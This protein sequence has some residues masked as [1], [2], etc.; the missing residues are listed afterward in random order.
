MGDVRLL[1][2][3]TGAVTVVPADKAEVEFRSGRAQLPVGA[4][5]KLVGTQSG[6]V[7]EF[8]PETVS[9]AIRDGVFRF[10]TEKDEYAAEAKN[11][12]VQAFAEGVANDIFLPGM[13]DLAA[14]AAGADMKAVAARRE[15]DEGQWGSRLGTVGSFV[16]PGLGEVRAL[17][18]ASRLAA[19]AMPNV[20]AEGA[21]RSLTEMAEKTLTGVIA[22][23]TARAAI[24]N[25]LGHGAVG[26]GVGALATLDEAALGNVE[27]ST[28]TILS[29]MGAGGLIGGVLGSGLGALGKRLSKVDG[30][31]VPGGAETAR[32]LEGGTAQ[33][34]LT[35]NEL[36]AVLEANGQEVDR[37]GLTK[38]WPNFM[39]KIANKATGVAE[40][41][42]QRVMSPAGRRAVL[43]GE[44]ARDAVTRHVSDLIDGLEANSDRFD[45]TDARLAPTVINRIPAGSGDAVIADVAGSFGA[46]RRTLA[47]LVRDAANYGMTPE[48]MASKLK[49]LRARIAEAEGKV[50]KELAAPENILTKEPKSYINTNKVD[51]DELEAGHLPSVKGVTAKPEN[52]EGFAEGRYT[53]EAPEQGV[54]VDYNAN[55][56]KLFENGMRQIRRVGGEG[57]GLKGKSTAGNRLLNEVRMPAEF[58]PLGLPKINDA[59]INSAEDLANKVFEHWRVRPQ[60]DTYASLVND[61][62][63]A[64]QR[65][66]GGFE[67][68]AESL[69][70]G[71][72]VPRGKTRIYDRELKRWFSDDEFLERNGRASRGLLADI[73]ERNIPVNDKAARLAYHELD[74][75]QRLVAAQ[76]R[77]IK[78]LVS[79]AGGLTD[80]SESLLGNLQ[81]EEIWGP[82]A[83]AHR[84]LTDAA[85]KELAARQAV[86]AHFPSKAGKVDRASVHSFTKNMDRVTGEPRV[87]ALADWVDAQNQLAQTVDR[88]TTRVGGGPSHFTAAPLDSGFR[89]NAK[90]L[91]NEYGQVYTRLREDAMALNA[92]DRLLKANR[93]QGVIPG[94]AL[95]S[96]L[97]AAGLGPAGFLGGNAVG[98][99]ILNPGRSARQLAAML[100]FKQQVA[101]HVGSRVERIFTGKGAIRQLPIQA[102]R[103]VTAMIDGSPKERQE[104]Y[105][106]HAKEMAAVSEPQAYVNH[107]TAGLGSVAEAMPQ[108]ASQLALQGQKTLA[109]L[110]NE[111]PKPVSTRGPQAEYDFLGPAKPGKGD[112]NFLNGPKRATAKPS[113]ENIRRYGQV[114]AVATGGTP[115]ILSAI[116]RGN[117]TAAQVR[118]YKSLFPNQDAD[119]TRQFTERLGRGHKMSPKV[120]RAL[121]L[122]LTTERGDAAVIG[123]KQ[124]LYA[125]NIAEEAGGAD[126]LP[127]PNPR[128][129][130]VIGPLSTPTDRLAGFPSRL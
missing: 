52:V 5:V 101:E 90:K 91:V 108:H 80:L 92:Q 31:S 107:V 124:S 81:K 56:D 44:K 126:T 17:T 35:A 111:Q 128:A 98:N 53:I 89:A 38:W 34:E 83:K 129:P 127:T 115:A 112:Y 41:D 68:E 24:A 65:R 99:A 10:A 47:G 100:A 42:V 32:A 25:G 73:A 30:R 97:A 69:V 71:M 84:E 22:N 33:A 55:P 16:L 104:A 110:A 123:F 120:A 45:V 51:L 40:E 77:K 72:A 113:P 121:K 54:R 95:G 105:E 7:H 103:L 102:P 57:L 117:L 18:G 85:R 8:D 1:D 96:L 28:E 43:E 86:A 125:E 26:A 62:K 46:A 27:A 119:L 82:A 130:T 78:P 109:Y 114:L 50:R 13:Y 66:I 118:A 87:Q 14:Q 60:P 11:H 64:A 36:A 122:Y 37:A 74:Q 29:G 58:R 63:A 70:D 116:E 75:L 19:K 23:D 93:A 9:D 88:H 49:P 39:A 21:A 2:P 12:P 106:Q 3:K 61:I 67:G 20:I 15:I 59:E 94:M 4:P 48:Q 79:E 6:E 76:E